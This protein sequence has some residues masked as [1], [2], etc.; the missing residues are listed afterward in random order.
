MLPVVAELLPPVR[1]EFEVLLPP[2]T[3]LALLLALSLALLELPPDMVLVLSPPFIVPP[4]SVF[5]PVLTSTP[6]PLD[7]LLPP[8]LLEVLPTEALLS[9]LLV[10]W[11]PEAAPPVALPP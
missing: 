4:V 1:F 11:L 10:L 9:L 2:V 3:L 7:R 5:D 6:T 8:E